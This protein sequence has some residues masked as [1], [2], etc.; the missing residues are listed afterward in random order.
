MGEEGVCE[1]GG[2]MFPACSPSPHRPLP[3]LQLA[4]SLSPHCPAQYRDNGWPHPFYCN[5]SKRFD[6]VIVLACKI[7]LSVQ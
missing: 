6:D 2:M 3:L 7:V 5:H 4:C 1:E